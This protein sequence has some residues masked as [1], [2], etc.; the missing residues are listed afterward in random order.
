MEDVDDGAGSGADSRRLKT[1][2]DT[3]WVQQI[4]C[5][6]AETPRDVSMLLDESSAD[7]MAHIVSRKDCRFALSLFDALE[8]ST[9]QVY[10]PTAFHE[11]LVK[12]IAASVEAVSVANAAA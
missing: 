11:P 5:P 1:D 3:Y 4:N 8:P 9:R 7:T 6:D 10:E 12:A 2:H